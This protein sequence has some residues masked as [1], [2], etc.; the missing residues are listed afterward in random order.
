MNLLLQFNLVTSMVEIYQNIIILLNKIDN[1]YINFNIFKYSPE[2][3]LL[4]LIIY[5]GNY[6]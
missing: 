4:E 3:V 1:L 6:R 5:I 2:P